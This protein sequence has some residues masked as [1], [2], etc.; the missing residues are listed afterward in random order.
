[1]LLCS[2]GQ[3][4]GIVPTDWAVIP[5]AVSAA[6]QY[7]SLD[8]PLDN[9][10]VNYNSLQQLSY[11]AVVFVAAPLAIATGAR[12]SALWPRDAPRLNRVY[13]FELAKAVHL[14]VMVF[15]VA[16]T[17]VHVALVLATGA[18]RNLNHIFAARDAGDWVGFGSSCSPCSGSRPAGPSSA[19]RSST[20]SPPPSAR[21]PAA[22][23]VLPAEWSVSGLEPAE[24]GWKPTAQRREA[25][26]GVRALQRRPERATSMG[27]AK[28]RVTASVVRA[29]S[30]GPDA[31]ARPAAS[32]STWVVVSG[33]SSR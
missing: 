16:F 25:A 21:S 15:F 22:D 4:M 29:S 13:R 5:N 27:C 30:I 9:G 33:S 23:P 26:R 19:P 8:W 24:W 18:L 2:T 10:W 3:W 20:A 7:A 11:V 1:V 32:S 17:V 28:V 14:P 12:M 6:L 31:T